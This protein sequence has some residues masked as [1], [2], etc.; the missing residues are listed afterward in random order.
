MSKNN[1]FTNYRLGNIID[2]WYFGSLGSKERISQYNSMMKAIKC[3]N[4]LARYFKLNEGISMNNNL[5]KEV[6]SNNSELFWATYDYNNLK[7]AMP[8]YGN[9]I[10]KIVDSYLLKNKNKI[11]K[12]EKNQLIIHYRLGDFIKDGIIDP[13]SLINVIKNIP[14]TYSKIEILNGGIYHQLENLNKYKLISINILEELK[15]NLQTIYPNATIILSNEN[16]PDIDFIKMVY[17]PILITGAGSFAITA[18]CANITASYIRTPSLENTNFPNSK[19]IIPFPITKYWNL[20]MFKLVI[21]DMKS[22]TP[23]KRAIKKELFGNE[24]LNESQLTISSITNI[25]E[26]ECVYHNTDSVRIKDPNLLDK[27]STK[28]TNTYKEG[29]NESNIINNHNSNKICLTSCLLHHTERIDVLKDMLNFI[30]YFFKKF[31]IEWS[32]YYG[33]LVGIYT[34]TDLLP[35]DTDLDIIVNYNDIDK[36]LDMSDKEL[37]DPITKK[38]YIFDIS[39]PTENKKDIIGRF[40]DKKHFYIQT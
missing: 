7:I 19:Q 1:E 16:N 32:L 31:N 6:L 25:L 15:K 18:A 34:R 23:S 14:I 10:R 26:D 37:T 12:Y 28:F 35:W 33:G 4:C 11:P 29:S 8:E 30:I 9:D 27:C 5:K 24:F 36:L 17:A 40:V 39:F 38:T 21:E 13:N 2:A 22:L 3:N 20:Y